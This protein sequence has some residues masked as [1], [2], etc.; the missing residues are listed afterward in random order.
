MKNFLVREG[1]GYAK[2]MFYKFCAP[3]L[4]T[5]YEKIIITDVDVVFLGDISKEFLQIDLS[6]S[7]IGAHK[8]FLKK[9]G[10]NYKY[11][12]LYDNEFSEDEKQAVQ[13]AGGYY[14]YNLKKM[15]QDN[16]EEKFLD[17]AIKNHKRLFQFEQDT[18]NIVCYPHIKPLQP[19]ALVCTYL[20]DIYKTEKDFNNDLN[21]SAQEIK[22]ALTHPIQLHF[23]TKIKPWNS[24]FCAKTEIFFS[25]LIQTPFL[26][27]ILKM[28]TLSAKQEMLDKEYWLKL[29]NLIP[30]IKVKKNKNCYLFNFIKIGKME[31]RR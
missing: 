11:L 2:E 5:Q 13:F 7:Y 20:Y 31:E 24:Y 18:I 10:L 4:F 9:N 6:N 26:N 25:Y 12:K 30:L 15:R 17:F 29:F 28:L 22:H 16:L 27:S 23:A 8:T 19:N 1:G 3:S 14:I 21:Y